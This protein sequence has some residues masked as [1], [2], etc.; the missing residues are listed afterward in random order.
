MS[1]N[2][3]MTLQSNESTSA[4]AP[5]T[6]VRLKSVGQARAADT[7]SKIDLDEL[8][9]RIDA[10]CGRVAPLWPLKHFVAVNPFFGLADH[11]FQDASDALARITGN[12]LYMSRDFLPRADGKRA[13]HLG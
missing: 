12:S 10:A 5:A 11:S 9:R 4:D 7:S 1:T 13:Y 2:Q 6:S 8:S 3:V